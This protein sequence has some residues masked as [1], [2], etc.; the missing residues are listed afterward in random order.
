MVQ[1]SRFEWGRI[2]KERRDRQDPG[3]PNVKFQDIKKSDLPEGFRHGPHS[4]VRRG[5]FI[6]SHHRTYGLNLLPEELNLSSE[7]LR[8]FFAGRLK[9]ELEKT[10]GVEITLRLKPITFISISKSVGKFTQKERLQAQFT[11]HS[12]H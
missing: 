12:T 8:E 7:S 5:F 3:R 4:L 2:L 9:K 6:E 1:R 11:M 10:H